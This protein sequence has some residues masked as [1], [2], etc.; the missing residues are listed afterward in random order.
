MLAETAHAFKFSFAQLLGCLHVL[1]RN[2]I[3]KLDARL[4]C[5]EF[6]TTGDPVL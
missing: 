3:A 5:N 6:E 2:E 4:A 1:S